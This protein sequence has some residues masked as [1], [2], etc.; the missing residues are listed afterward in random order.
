VTSEDP[1]APE[2]KRGWSWIWDKARLVLINRYL[3]FFVFILAAAE[4]LSRMSGLSAL[5]S[6]PRTEAPLLLFLYW[7]LNL[8]L[9]PRKLSALVAAVPIVV[10][11]LG[12]DV[13]F[14]YWGSVFKVIDAQNL[15]TLLKVL[16]LSMKTGLLLTLG[17]PIV[18]M[19]FFT[20]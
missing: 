15:P 13:F 12:F 6:H 1:K 19:L 20:D 18:L 17:L 9:K 16:P 3:I 2:S 5:R 8:V 10:I 4:L 14:L 7:A 11:Y